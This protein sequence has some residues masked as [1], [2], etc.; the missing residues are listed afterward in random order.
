MICSSGPKFAHKDDIQAQILL[1]IV[2]SFFASV[3][4]LQVNLNLLL[5]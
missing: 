1:S 3:M 5:T 2:N 4:V